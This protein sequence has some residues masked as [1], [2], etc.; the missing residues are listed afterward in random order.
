LG[1]FLGVSTAILAAIIKNRKRQAKK[2]RLIISHQLF[3]CH[4]IT[5]PTLSQKFC[6]IHDVYSKILDTTPLK[7]LHL[8]VSRSVYGK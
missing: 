1:N 7:N 4:S 3:N 8:T 6:A 5:C 2:L